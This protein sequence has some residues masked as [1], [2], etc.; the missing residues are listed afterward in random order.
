MLIS[1]FALSTTSEDE[2]TFLFPFVEEEEDD[3]NIDEVLLLSVFCC[4][5]I[6]FLPPLFFHFC[7]VS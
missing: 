6:T 3:D 5:T 1:Y 4:L 2:S 7:G